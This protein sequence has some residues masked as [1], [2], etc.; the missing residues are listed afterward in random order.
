MT[1]AL[2]AEVEAVVTETLTLEPPADTHGDHHV[3]CALFQNS[4][5]YTF[6]HIIPAAVLDDHGVDMV[7]MQKMT[8]QESRR[9]RSYDSHL[10]LHSHPVI[11]NH[12]FSPTL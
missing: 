7:Q 3:D 10:S 8:Q 1:P 6:D 12:S 11:L 5:A 9:P 2:E 4:R